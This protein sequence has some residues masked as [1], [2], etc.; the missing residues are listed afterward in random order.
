MASPSIRSSN[1]LVV[2]IREM[3]RFQQAANFA[4][5]SVRQVLCPGPESARP[6]ESLVDQSRGAVH[7]PLAEAVGVL[8]RVVDTRHQ[9]VLEGEPLP[10]ALAPAIY[11]VRLTQAGRAVSTR[12]ATVQ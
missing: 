11:L 9:H 7:H 6:N 5:V 10:G 4:R 1:R 3:G 2:W 8:Q 12:M